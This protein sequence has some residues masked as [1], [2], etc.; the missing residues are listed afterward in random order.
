MLLPRARKGGYAPGELNQSLMELGATVCTPRGPRCLSCP[1]RT[2]CVA[3]ASGCAE[4]LPVKGARTK[5]TPVTHRVLAVARRGKLLF[6]QRPDNGLWAGMWQ[7]PTCENGDTLIDWL[8]ARFGL[9]V[10]EDGLVQ[11][12]SFTHLTTHRRITFELYLA[13]NVT[14]RLRQS[15]ATW[16]KADGVTDLPMSNPQRKVL[17]MLDTTDE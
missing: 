4:S 10:N 8:H 7:M 16:R 1:V 3:A 2:Y 13:R 15:C 5:Q 11:V 12:G 17:D 9:R 14:G 6:E